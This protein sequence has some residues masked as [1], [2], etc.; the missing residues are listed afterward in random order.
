MPKIKKFT[1]KLPINRPKVN[2]VV[3]NST[4]G[5]SKSAFTILGENRKNI[6]NPD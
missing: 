5:A 3:N 1:I 6:I 4:G 2:G